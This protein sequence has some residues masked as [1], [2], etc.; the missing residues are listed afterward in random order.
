MTASR[1]RTV[2]RVGPKSVS[3]R[4]RGL[5]WVLVAELVA[6]LL[7]FA[8]MVHLARRLGPA[9]FAR[10]EYAAAVAAW[11]LVLVRGGVDVIVYRE[12]ARRPSL[13]R[14]LT[15]VLI[16]LRG[17]AALTGYA[18]ILGLAVLAGPERGPV[19]A[20]A[21]LILIPSALVTD[22]GLR[23]SGRFGW[24]ALAQGVRSLAYVGLAVSLVRNPGDLLRAA[25][26]VVFAEVAGTIVPLA[27]HLGQLGWPRVRFRKRAWIVVARRG[28]IAGVTRFGRVSLYGADLLVLGWWASAELG[29][30]AA[31]RRIVF[32]F[33][34][35]GLVLPASLAPAIAR[36]WACGANLARGLIEDSLVRIWGLSLPAVLVLM[37][38]AGRWM[39]LLFGEHYREGGPWL[40]LIAARLPWLLTASFI[41]AALTACRRES[42]VFDQTVGL[43]LLAL[44]LVPAAAA[45][46]GPWGVGWALLAIEI[47][48]AVGGLRMLAKLGLSP[49]WYLWRH[50][51]R[52]LLP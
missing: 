3:R 16:G 17:L 26:S 25:W 2:A 23:A 8:V 18:L 14:P 1:P 11:L 7:G 31:A 28:A 51:L 37:V 35:L 41:Q 52:G 42:W 46:A 12:A 24:I 43:V 50:R 40:V 21:G 47:V 29:S 13:I 44:V 9:S 6:N 20:I 30:Y 19:V 32:G 34:A 27:W 22:V 45:W 36:Q 33:V 10:L 5:R 15:D 48:A 4:P 39:P 38:M 49:R